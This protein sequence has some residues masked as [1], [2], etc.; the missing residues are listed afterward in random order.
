[1]NLLSLTAR[2]IVVNR[3]KGTYRKGERETRFF[4][5]TC[6]QRPSVRLCIDREFAEELVSRRTR[7]RMEWERVYGPF[8]DDPS[9]YREDEGTN[10]ESSV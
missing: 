2:R 4:L 1:M 9:E 5:Q 3:K 10:P 7:A 8:P 6:S